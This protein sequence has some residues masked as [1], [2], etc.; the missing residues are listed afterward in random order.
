MTITPD[1]RLTSTDRMRYTK[2]S[3]SSGLILIAI[4]FD[5]LFF[6]L[7]YR[8]DV[9]S[10]YYTWKIGASIIYNLIFMLAAFLASEEVKNRK[11]GNGT[12]IL[13]LV[14]AVIQ[15]VR[16][17]IFPVQAHSAV[18]TVSGE[19]VQ[20]LSDAKFF[21]MVIYLVA[22]AVCLVI[23]AITHTAQN[24]TLGD[25]LSHIDHKSE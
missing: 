16:I 13:L 22:S 6:V 18:V 5:V 25:Y 7:L 9:E 2:N 12:M 10:Y 19:D 21:R 1:E 11:P 8:Q 14:L 17:F 23:A 3:F 20:V 15:I 4:V 24:K